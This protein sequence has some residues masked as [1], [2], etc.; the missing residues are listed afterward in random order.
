MKKSVLVPLQIMS[1]TMDQ[2]LAD[3]KQALG[4]RVDQVLALRSL[5]IKLGSQETSVKT[6]VVNMSRYLAE[7]EAQGKPKE[8]ELK[9][10]VAAFDKIRA[11]AATVE[12]NR[13]NTEL[14]LA[15]KESEAS[16]DLLGAML[17]M[18]SLALYRLDTI[19]TCLSKLA[20]VEQSALTRLNLKFEGVLTDCLNLNSLQD[21]I[22]MAEDVQRV[23]TES[24]ERTMLEINRHASQGAPE[25]HQ[26]VLEDDIPMAEVVPRR[27]GQSR[28]WL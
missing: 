3:V 18:E 11:E 6:T 10:Q 1:E 12:R 14:E 4:P 28:R 15:M 22:A 13:A 17:Q 24:Q 7:L 21:L 20:Y 27:R 5:A 25:V 19:K 8:K 16:E 2:S 23:A 9:K 26:A